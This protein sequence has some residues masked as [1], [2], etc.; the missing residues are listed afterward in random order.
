MTHELRHIIE[1]LAAGQCVP[2]LQ[3]KAAEMLR[4]AE[5]QSDIIAHL[6]NLYVLGGAPSAE[7]MARVHT[8]ITN[9]ADL[10]SYADEAPAHQEPR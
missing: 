1:C 7:T 2:S 6:A 8:C 3:K 9:A 10:F 5:E 4:V